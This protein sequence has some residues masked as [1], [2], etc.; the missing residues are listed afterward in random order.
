MRQTEKAGHL[1]EGRTVEGLQVD[2]KV[3]PYDTHPF[4]DSADQH[5]R[6]LKTKRF[7]AV[8]LCSALGLSVF[9]LGAQ[10]PHLRACGT[11]ARAGVQEHLSSLSWGGHAEASAVCPQTTAIA[12][13][14]NSPF[15]DALEAEFATDAFKLKA[16]ESL[17]GAIRVPTVAYDDLK[18]PGQDERWEIFG[19]LHAYLEQHFPLLHQNLK[20][21]HVNKYALVYHWQGSD[22]SLKP[23]LLTAHQD[24]VPV[25]PLTI[26]VW[27]HPPFSGFYDGEYIWGRGS[28]DDKP[29]LIGTL[30][31]VEELL[32]IGFKPT[33]SIV[34]AYGID[35]ERGGIS[36][37]T[38]IR[39]YLLGAYGENAFSILIDEGGGYEVGEDAITSSP[40]V[41]EKGKFDVRFEISAPGGHSSV[42]PE[43]TSI[44]MIAA[45]IKQL[46]AN[47]HVAHLNRSGIYYSLLQCQAEHDPALPSHL[48]K[49]ITHSRKSDKALSALE[50]ELARTDRKFRALA[51]TTQA[52]D[53]VRGGVKTNALPE[54]ASVIVNHRIDVHSSVGF[55]KERITRVV[56]PVA[57]RFGLDVDA[58]GA[59]TTA[60]SASAGL[61]R[62][63]D[64]FG[65]AL[66]PAPVTPLGD[67]GPFQL[68]SGTIIGVLG[69]SNRTGYDK[70]TFIA[71]GMSTGNTAA[72]LASDTK[73][74]WKLTKHI[75]RYGHINA[76]DSFNGAHT[77]NEALRAEG[78][79]EAIRFFTWVILNADE[80]PLLE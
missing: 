24:V 28:C 68:L 51:G 40:A 4:H 6:G 30:T 12:P 18:P 80:S 15:L 34:L 25:E 77:V 46:E 16:Y 58:F 61:L 45:V 5:K 2:E 43:H 37:A 32:R 60:A 27:Q 53:V 22:D 7:F 69:S 42:P 49:L 59:K 38:A 26:D 36:G 41:A 65:T 11:A 3:N 10:S 75:F 66:E 33:R 20:K 55:L 64:A 44:G 14:K 19:D 29:G 21:T 9:Y 76:G 23:A 1:Y 35:E 74:Y 67:S 39:D 31:A 79:I 71:P 47:P 62:I 73:H 8:A 50:A 78:F 52:A 13:Q 57:E 17:G 72:C 48:R 56:S 54:L 70:K 63:S